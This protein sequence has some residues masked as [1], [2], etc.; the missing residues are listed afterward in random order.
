[1]TLGHCKLSFK[2]QEA[3]DHVIECL[4]HDSRINQHV[5]DGVGRPIGMHLIFICKPLLNI[6]AKN[7]FYSSTVRRR[8]LNICALDELG[9]VAKYFSAKKCLVHMYCSKSSR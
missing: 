6:R 8:Q 9:L 2:M 3:H 4:G 7:N 5:M 1:M